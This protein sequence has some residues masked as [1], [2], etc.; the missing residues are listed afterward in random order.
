MIIQLLLLFVLGVFSIVDYYQT[1]A[2]IECGYSEAN[3]VVLAL[4][5]GGT[6]WNN[7]LIIKV[8]MVVFVGILLVINHYYKKRRIKI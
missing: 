5:G 2:L 7:L 1:V 8:G 6:H 4:T 3:P